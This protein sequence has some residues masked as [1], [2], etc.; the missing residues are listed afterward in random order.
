[1][2]TARGT[3]VVAAA[4]AMLAGSEA[5]ATGAG[6]G[7]PAGTSRA[8]APAPSV[9]RA[10]AAARAATKATGATARVM[11]RLRGRGCIHQPIGGLQRVPADWNR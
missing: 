10:T 8:D 1:M 2:R 3:N 11:P 4:D 7:R 9:P 5:G 6:T